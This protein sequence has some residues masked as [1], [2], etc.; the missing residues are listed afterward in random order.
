V[1][2]HQRTEFPEP[3]E[4]RIGN[5]RNT[6]KDLKIFNMIDDSAMKR[7]KFLMQD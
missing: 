5:S 4:S 3:A 6:K 2:F 1:L 7:N